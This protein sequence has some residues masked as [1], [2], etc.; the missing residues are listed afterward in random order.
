MQALIDFIEE[1][2]S[3]FEAKCEEREVDPEEILNELKKLAGIV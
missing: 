2:W 3:A 1:N